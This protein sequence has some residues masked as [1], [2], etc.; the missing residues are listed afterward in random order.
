[1]R[2]IHTK[3][4]VGLL[5]LQ[6]EVRRGERRGGARQRG[7]SGNGDSGGEGQKR[8]KEEAAEGRREKPGDRGKEQGRKGRRTERSRR[9]V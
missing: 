6:L 7:M 5:P 9:G 1:M 2:L 4:P 3:C 8:R